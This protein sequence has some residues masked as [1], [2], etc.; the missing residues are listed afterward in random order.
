MFT[1]SVVL[2][3]IV[4]GVVVHWQVHEQT[5]TMLL[6]LAQ[7]EADGVL[8]EFDDG[9]HVHDTALRLPSLSSPAVEKFSIAYLPK[10]LHVLA[11]TSNFTAHELPEVWRLGLE[12]VGDSKVFDDDHTGPEPLRIGA[13]TARAPNGQ[14]LVFATAVPH[15]V[16]D[17]AVR[18]TI[19]LIALLAAA[20]LA[21]MLVASN[22][23][24]RR[25]T[26]DLQELS[27]KCVELR[28]APEQLEKWLESFD[29]SQRSTAETEALAS[30][31]HALV[32]RLQRLVDVQNR[33]VAEASHELRTPLTALKGELE[34]ALRRERDPEA[35]REFIQNAQID[36]ERLASLAEHLLEA[37]R[38][39]VEELQPEEVVLKEALQEAVG[40]NAHALS[41]A[42]IDVHLHTDDSIVC[43]DTI[44]TARVLDNLIGNAARHSRAQ[45]L[46]IGCKDGVVTIQ[47]DGRGISSDVQDDLFAPFAHRTGNGHGLGLFIAARLMEKQRGQLELEA[48]EGTSWR[49]VFPPRNT[50]A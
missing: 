41:D 48:G 11:S 6:Q 18:Q 28:D 24:A 43:A 17:T 30:T 39:R 31:I 33:F 37:A 40:R 44:A 14:I 15:N 34:L 16:I 12:N 2:F 3:T 13:V 22:L 29:S 38:S 35:Y 23:V 8:S 45:N 27:G 4:V 46:T 20:M 42:Q 50:P 5:D 26:E 9:V 47:D 32:A 1:I 19:L 25:I 36:A 49:L 7:T 10:D 21:A